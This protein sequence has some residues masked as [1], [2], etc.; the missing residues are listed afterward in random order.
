MS[1]G[2]IV[3][4]F[5]AC[6]GSFLNVLIDR[7]PK[8]QGV[9]AGRSRCDYCKNILHWYELVPLLSWVIQGGRCRRCHK[10]LSWQYPLVELVTGVGFIILAPSYWLIFSVLLVIF[11]ADLKEQIIPD[12]MVIAGVIGAIGVN[13]VIGENIL[14]GMGASAFF[15]FL[16]LI[17]RGRAMG[18]GDVKFAFL[19]GFLLGFPGIFVACYLAFLTGAGVGV[20]LIVSGRKGLKSKISFGPFLI[21]GTVVTLVWSTQIIEWWRRLL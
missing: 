16:W 7:L 14:A 11:M 4:I 13:G 18:L 1:V 19:M 8:G 3:F 10:R 17:T 21:I 15:L 20:I 2:F 5:G 6:V 12:S 9:I